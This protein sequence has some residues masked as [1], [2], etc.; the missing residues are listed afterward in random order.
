MTVNINIVQVILGIRATRHV[1]FNF[2]CSLYGSSSFIILH[3]QKLWACCNKTSQECSQRYQQC[4]NSCLFGFSQQTRDKPFWKDDFSQHT[5]YTLVG[6]VGNAIRTK[7]GICMWSTFKLF[8][9]RG[10][11]VTFIL[12]LLFYSTA[13]SDNNMNYFH[14]FDSLGQCVSMVMDL[15]MGK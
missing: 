15:V 5:I 6:N 13:K 7:K 8:Q 11:R 9:V 10:V 4:K 12:E 14:L 3:P 2:S 1:V